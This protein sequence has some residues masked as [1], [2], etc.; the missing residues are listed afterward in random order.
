M[1]V[2]AFFVDW[3]IL[4]SDRGASSHR[5]SNVHCMLCNTYQIHRAIPRVFLFRFSEPLVALVEAATLAITDSTDCRP[6]G[7]LMSLYDF[8]RRLDIYCMRLTL[9]RLFGIS[10]RRDCSSYSSSA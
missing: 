9:G 7:Y 2:A 1:K 8:N 3:A 5:S 6:I 4:V 10:M